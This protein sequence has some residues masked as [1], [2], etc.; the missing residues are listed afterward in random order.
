MHPAHLAL[1]GISALPGFQA[2]AAN[3]RRTEPLRFRVSATRAD[4]HTSEW[5]AIGGN[6]CDHALT[7]MD[8]AGLGGVVRVI[9]ITEAEAA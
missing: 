4:G 9:D 6:S 1:V 5:T 8:A 7:A 3:T 2:V